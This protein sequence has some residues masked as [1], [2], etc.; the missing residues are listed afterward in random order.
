MLGIGLTNE[1]VIVYMEEIINNFSSPSWWVTAIIA[2]VFASLT[3]SY[4]KPFVDKFIGGMSD[5]YR[6]KVETKK[7]D[8]L[9]HIESLKASPNEQIVT[10]L[11][12]N[13]HRLRSIGFLLLGVII[14]TVS[15]TIVGTGVHYAFPAFL[16]AFSLILM[17][18]AFGDVL[19]A[20]K[21]R[22]IVFLSRSKNSNT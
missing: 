13:H 15:T 17:V 8:E 11:N 4:A 1:R 16:G 10:L 14:M 3:A 19:S 7:N 12:A 6:A 9:K 2:G 5:K 18:A 21:L 22:R 20:Q